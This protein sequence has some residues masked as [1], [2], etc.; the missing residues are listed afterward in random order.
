MIWLGKTQNVKGIFLS[1]LAR[2]EATR[3]PYLSIA[4][5]MEAVES[6]SHVDIPLSSQGA[7]PGNAPASGWSH[8][9]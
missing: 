8:S 2:L 3:T 4:M 5:Y 6:V 7:D 9:A 1:R